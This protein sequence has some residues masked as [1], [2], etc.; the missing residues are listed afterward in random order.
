M[1]R[2][3]DKLFCRLADNTVMTFGHYMIKDYDSK[4]VLVEIK[5]DMQEA[6]H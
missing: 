3:S 6:V 1:T 5:E 2:A 4:E